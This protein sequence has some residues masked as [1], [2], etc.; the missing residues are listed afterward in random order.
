[1]TDGLAPTLYLRDWPRNPIVL[2][3]GY[4]PFTMTPIEL[5]SI[6]SHYH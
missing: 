6:A 2:I 5:D 4:R 1:V 3:H